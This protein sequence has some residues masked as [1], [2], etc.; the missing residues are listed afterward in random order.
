M[1]DLLAEYGVVG[2]LLLDPSYLPQVRARITATD[3]RTE[4]ARSVYRLICAMSDAGEPIDPMTVSGRTN[5]DQGWFVELLDLLPTAHNCL[6]YVTLMRRDAQ[7]AA[8]RDLSEQ[9][10]T[11]VTTKQASP[12]AIAVDAMGVLDQIG[13]SQ[14]QRIFNNDTA[15]IEFQAHRN[16]MRQGGT[17]T[18]ST[19]FPSIDRILGGGFIRTGL[20]ILG[21]RPGVGKTSLGLMIAD[22]AAKRVPTL[23][24]S[25]EMDTVEI[26]ARRVANISGCGIGRLLFGQG[27]R[28]DMDEKAHMAEI[29]LSDTRHLFINRTVSATVAEIGLMARECKAELVV[30]DYLGLI[31]TKERYA[32]SYERISKI[33]RTLK[34]LARSLRC[35]ILCL[36]QLNRQSEGRENRR[37]QISDIRDSGAVEQDADGIL[38]IHRP[39]MYQSVTERPPDYQAQ[40]FEVNIGK[41]RHGPTGNATLQWIPYNGRFQDGTFCSW[42]D[43]EPQP[44]SNL[45]KETPVP[46]EWEPEQTTI[47]EE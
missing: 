46:A 19:G 7:Y 33:S 23:F 24:V 16:M 15:I 35:P 26:T 47:K 44:V 8:L 9:L 1:L 22:Q 12:D 17:F 18:V 14:E 30:V 3:F 25:L 32:S 45:P 42:K 21:A 6:Q 13:K 36:A 29:L 28:Q 40:P 27:L 43:P 39:A 20:Y 31:E 2:S 38:L 41:N 37:P 34:Q 10:E 11:S 4:Q 5:I